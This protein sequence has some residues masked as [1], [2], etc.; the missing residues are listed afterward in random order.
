MDALASEMDTLTVCEPPRCDACEQGESA[1]VGAIACCG[2]LAD[3]ATPAAEQ[4]VLL[5]VTPCKAVNTAGKPGE[6]LQ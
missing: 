1:A 5:V 6:R 4:E 2:A 3:D